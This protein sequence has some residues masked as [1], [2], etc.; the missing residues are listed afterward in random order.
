MR[1][2]G[3]GLEGRK[4]TVESKCDRG[5]TSVKKKKG[6]TSRGGAPTNSGEKKVGIR[7]IIGTWGKKTKKL[8]R[9]I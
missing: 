9:R 5:K 7:R 2:D 8:S 4:K 1:G 3:K 6:A